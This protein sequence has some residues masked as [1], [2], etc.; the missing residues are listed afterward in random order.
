MALRTTLKG[1]EYLRKI[2]FYLIERHY[3]KMTYKSKKNILV[4]YQELQYKEQL[5]WELWKEV[6]RTSQTPE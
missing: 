3:P 4:W 2:M 1:F 6:D 5:V